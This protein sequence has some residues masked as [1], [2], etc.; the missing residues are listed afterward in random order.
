MS[1]FS[2]VFCQMKFFD[3]RD[4]FLA[5]MTLW[6]K[7]LWS[8]EFL[9][10]NGPH[11]AKKLQ[12]FNKCSCGLVCGIQKKFFGLFLI[13]LEVQWYAKIMYVSSISTLP[14]TKPKFPFRYIVMLIGEFCKCTLHKK[15]G[16]IECLYFLWNF[17]SMV[18]H[19]WVSSLLLLLLPCCTILT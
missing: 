5:F 10:Q 19:T 16:E 15:N 1:W 6:L 7:L 11:K 9:C 2:S 18:H 13:F 4:Q 3:P 8:A 17:S 12:N 14:K